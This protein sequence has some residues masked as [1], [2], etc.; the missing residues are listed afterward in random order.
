M[1]DTKNWI[2]HMAPQ[3]V[4]DPDRFRFADFAKFSELAVWQN[5]TSPTR[6]N[7][8]PVHHDGSRTGFRHP[9]RR[10]KY[11][12]IRELSVCKPKSPLSNRQI[13]EF[14]EIGNGTKVDQPRRQNS[15]VSVHNCQK[16]KEEI[17][18]S[19]AKLTRMKN[20]IFS[21]RNLILTF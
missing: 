1:G 7:G 6:P 8:F 13:R 21:W 9:Y 20:I 11:R 14:R 16:S 2:H 15:L 10:G 17:R 12:G 5:C 18:T 19:S 4:R 3:H